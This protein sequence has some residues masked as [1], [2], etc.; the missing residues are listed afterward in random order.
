LS[1][2]SADSPLFVASVAKCFKV[3]RVF[4]GPKREMT[5]VEIARESGLDRSAAQRMVYTLEVL[6][7]LTRVPGTKAFAL[8]SRLLQFSYNYV[9]KHELIAKAMPYMQELSATFKETVNLQELDGTEI[10]L[11]ARVFSPHLMNIRVAAGSRFPAVFTAS[12]TAML[13]TMSEQDRHDVVGASRAEPL[14]PHTETRR[15]QLLARIEQAALK[16]YSILTDQAAMGDISLAA[17]IRGPG[18]VAIAALNISVPSSRWTPREVEVK[19][20]KHVQACARALSVSS[21]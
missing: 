19:M 3:L 10:V 20:A 12:G 16:G 6:G 9:R 2:P 14:T 18:G 8:T 4:D 7:Y 13:S 5:L 15:E 1:T 11:I 21:Q 17:P